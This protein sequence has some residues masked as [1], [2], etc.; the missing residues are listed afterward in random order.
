ME[1]TSQPPNRWQQIFVAGVLGA[2]LVHSAL[3]VLWVSPDNAIRDRLSDRLTAYVNPYFQ[4][5]WSGLDPRLERVDETLRIRAVVIHPETGEEITTDWIDPVNLDLENAGR[6]SSDRTQEI[7]RLLAV[8]LNRMVLNLEPAHR[9]IIAEDYLERTARQ[10]RGDLEEVGADSRDAANYALT[11]RMVMTYASMYA[12]AYWQ[13][14]IVQV[15]VR[16]G[17]RI[18]GEDAPAAVID[19]DFRNF[20]IGWRDP[21]TVTP[22]AQRDFARYVL[23]RV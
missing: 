14:R 13:G 18:L 2:V 23:G 6:L 5:T 10:I 12:D 21:V 4:Q 8:N 16:P 9:Q 22:D 7:S 1:A 11:E 19:Q 15:Q 20:N 3:I 17:I